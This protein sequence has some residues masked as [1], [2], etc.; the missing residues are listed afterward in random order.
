AKKLRYAAEFFGEAYGEA[1]AKRRRAFIGALKRFQDALG[2]LNDIAVARQ[3]T[4]ALV[5]NSGA[6]LAFAAGLLVGE[7]SR[8]E[9]GLLRTAEACYAAFRRARPFW[10]PADA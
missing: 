2:E 3:S 1:P 8:D 9:E 7:R 5:R 4:A 6:R 10:Q